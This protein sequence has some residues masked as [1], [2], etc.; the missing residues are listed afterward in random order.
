VGERSS[1]Q[2]AS[3]RST[4]Q[5]AS[6]VTGKNVNITS[7]RDVLVKG[8]QLTAS[9]DVTLRA[10]QDLVIAS[11]Q[12]TSESSQSSRK[13]ESGASADILRGPLIGDT[14]Q[15][16]KGNTQSTTQV[17]SAITGRNI[18]AQ[19]ARDATVQASKLL[20][21][22]NITLSA[23]RNTFIVAAANLANTTSQT[24][25]NITSTILSMEDKTR[26]D[27]RLSSTAVG[28]EL[29]AGNKIEVAIGNAALLSGAQLSAQ[30]IAFTR[31]PATGEDVRAPAQLILDGAANTLQVSRT[32]K[33]DTLG[34]WQSATGAGKTEQTLT[35]TSLKGS[36]SFDPTLK[37]SV[38]LPAGELKT[39]LATLS[40]QPG[41]D[42]LAQLAKRDDVNWQGVKLAHDKWDYFAPFG[43]VVRIP[44]L[45]ESV[46]C[47]VSA[48]YL[49]HRSNER[50]VRVLTSNGA[51]VDPA[52]AR[53]WW[54]ERPMLASS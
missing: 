16:S 26:A 27:T 24:N 40:A 15:A 35:Q 30:D 25:S 45:L 8:S 2:D 37:I 43:N 46:L 28:S 34:L 5:V 39:Q 54:S 10:G 4:T 13:T 48:R 21:E 18:S 1:A 53:Q 31:T 9:Q 52:Y 14:T 6:T 12:N 36:T 11:A 32:E 47:K 44:K 7:G 51:N 19:A 22:Q 42:Y 38:T 23:Q 20:A 17:A 49:Y 50:G 29:V 41:M 33:G 3:Q